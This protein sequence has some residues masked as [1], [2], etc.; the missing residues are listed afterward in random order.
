[1]QA[2]RAERRVA[3]ERTWNQSAGAAATFRNAYGSRCAEL[4]VET[5]H[6]A[7]VS[8]RSMDWLGRASIW[9]RSTK[10]NG[11]SGLAFL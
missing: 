1:M 7:L 6:K 3:L 9:D 4:D 5:G 2:S 8:P 11:L 10:Q